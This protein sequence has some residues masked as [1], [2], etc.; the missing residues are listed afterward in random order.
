MENLHTDERI[1]SELE[2]CGET[3]RFCLSLQLHKI[4]HPRPAQNVEATRKCRCVRAG[5]Q[6]PGVLPGSHQLLPA[7]DR[8]AREQVVPV[9]AAEQTDGLHLLRAG[10]ERAALR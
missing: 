8:E 3:Q 7:E 4:L 6:I 1:Y 10:G 2:L 5:G 9:P